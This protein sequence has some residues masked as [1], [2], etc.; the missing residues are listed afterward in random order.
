MLK[1]IRK[2]QL[3]ILAI[4]GSLLMVVFLLEPVITS[5]QRS[6]NNRTVARFADGTTIGAMDRARASDELQLARAIAPMVFAPR[7]QG[8]LGLTANDSD[9]ID[10]AYHWLML[11]RLVEDAGLDGGAS[12]GQALVDISAELT[13]RQFVQQNMMAVFQG[14]ISQEELLDQAQQVTEIVRSNARREVQ[15]LASRTRG[16]TPEDIWRS[17]A[18][19]QGAYRLNQLYLTAPAYSPEGAR[20]G[21]AEISDAVAMDAALIPGSM[22]AHTIPDPTEAELRAFF[23]S[24]AGLEPS[25]DEYGIGYAQPARVQIAWLQLDRSRFLAAVPTDRVEL[26]KIWER[27]SQRPEAERQFPG[28][29]ASE[30]SRIEEQYRSERA[31]RLMVEADQIIR[32]KVLGATRQLEK[33]GDVIVLPE[34]WATTRPAF[35][36]IAEA[37][38]TEFAQRDI[39]IATP[40]IEQ[41]DSRWLSATDLSQLPTVGRSFFRAGARATLVS[42]LP[43]LIDDRGRIDAI[44]FQVG[45]PQVD[46]AAQDDAGNRYYLLVTDDLPAG[47]ARSIDDAGRARVIEDYKSVRGYENLLMIQDILT[48]AAESTEGVSAAVDVAAGGTL[49][50]GVQRPGVY[51]NIRVSQ[52]RIDQGPIARSVDQRLNQPAFREAAVAL[53]DDIDPL[54]GPE[55]FEDDPIALTVALPKQRSIAIAR[56]IAPRPLTQEDFLSRF[57]QS[58]TTLNGM[59]LRDAIESTDATDPFSYDGLLERFGLDILDQ[60]DNAS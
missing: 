11:S 8:G 47:P 36:E 48:D 43:E 6:A 2:Y 40:T 18:K 13:A 45:V 38:V 41:L 31:D 21:V 9:G 55:W 20:A 35:S 27:D 26:R 23:E 57:R 56:V 50:E 33:D 14:A 46:P 24:R 17:L 30:R 12:D 32:G 53:L 19:F 34:D 42:Q 29:F 16:A 54:A 15:A 49:P 1:F 25:E 3:I 10:P 7:T 5:F 4:G 28:D 59:G 39:T 51:P 60:D 37:I 58:L 52:M 44:G 22:L